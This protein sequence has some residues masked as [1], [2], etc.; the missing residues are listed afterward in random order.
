M[1]VTP[2]VAALSLAMQPA[3]AQTPAADTDTAQTVVVQGKRAPVVRRI[4]RNVYKADSDIQSTSGSAADLLNTLPS[5]DVNSDGQVSLRGDAGVTILI[6]GKPSS[7]VKGA[8]GADGLSQIPASD[9][10]RIEI[11]T[12]PSAEFKSDGSAGV[13]NII[14]KTARKPGTT[15]SAQAYL[16]AGGRYNLGGTLA[17]NTRKLSLSGSVTLRRDKRLREIIDDRHQ[18]DPLTGQ[19]V[20]SHHDLAEHVSR[21]IAAVKTAAAYDVTDR[22][23]IGASLSWMER[24]GDRYFQQQ[25]E[26]Y[27]SASVLDKASTRHSD[28]KEWRLDLDQG[29]SYDRRLARDGETLS[30]NLRRTI[31]REREN[32][33]Y[34]NVYTQP[35]AADSYDTLHLGLDL[36]TTDLSADYVLPMPN[37]GA[38]KLGYDFTRDDN[39]YDNAGTRLDPATGRY[40]SDPNITNHFRYYQA[41]QALYA[42]YETQSGPFDVLGGLRVESARV[43]THQITGELANSSAY[44]HAYPS[45]HVSYSLSEADKLL[46]SYSQRVERPDPEDLNPFSDHQDTHNLRAGNPNLKPAEIQSLEGGYS[47]EAPALTYTATAFCRDTHNA[48]SDVIQVISED[49]ILLTKTNIPRTRAGGLEGTANGKLSPKLSYNL[50]GNLFYNELDVQAFG[51]SRPRSN[52]ATNL[53]AS[54]DFK[55]TSADTWQVSSNYTGKRLTAQGYLLPVLTVN[56]GY[57]RQIKSGLAMVVTVSD[58]FNGQKFQRVIDTPAVQ[59]RYTRRLAGQVVYVGIT[60]TGAG[61]KKAKTAFDYE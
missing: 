16:G 18:I 29:L 5:V 10:D 47:H 39:G 52:I 23:K 4:D 12:N 15:G 35:L 55:P 11:I 44:T 9:I 54:L 8:S 19:T 26:A 37:G 30:V 27:D 20:V 56:M 61:A 32:Y 60:Y 38:L 42:T 43:R 22:D 48:V 13:I 3:Y 1:G 53:K 51:A 34:R 33:A 36:V 46:A 2:A 41:V 40:E 17:L 24:H 58:A 31:T 57:R 45:L 49:V 50:S 6:N 14:L 21:Q 59:D 7:Q 28:G 25:D